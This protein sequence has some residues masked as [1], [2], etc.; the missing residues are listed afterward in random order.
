MIP[1]SPQRRR[2]F[3]EGWEELGIEDPSSNK[4]QHG[5][6]YQEA[7]AAFDQF[8]THLEGMREDPEKRLGRGMAHQVWGAG[9]IGFEEFFDQL[10]NWRVSSAATLYNQNREAFVYLQEHAEEVEESRVWWEWSQQ[11]VVVHFLTLLK[12]PDNLGYGVKIHGGLYPHKGD[13][14]WQDPGEALGQVSGNTAQ[15]SYAFLWDPSEVNNDPQ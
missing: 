3:S 10:P 14:T 9:F 8:K 11:R 13:L 1:S 12:L 6:K 5:P 2:L 4:P 7:K 15:E